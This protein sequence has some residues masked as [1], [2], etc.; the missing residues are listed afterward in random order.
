MKMLLTL[1]VSGALLVLPAAETKSNRKAPAPS[2]AANSGA[3]PANAQ[4][5]ADGSYLSTD[6]KGKRWTH[7]QTPFGWARYEEQA[8]PANANSKTEEE[9]TRVIEDVGDRVK[10][11]K[12]GPFGTARWERKKSELTA[13]ER[14]VLDKHQA[15]SSREREKP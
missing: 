5:Q 4:K 3:P 1:L 14:A 10:F 6:A 8:P 15:Q 7:R 2:K 11:E 13:T 12:P 9:T